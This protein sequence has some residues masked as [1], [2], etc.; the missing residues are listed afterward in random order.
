MSRPEAIRHHDEL[1]IAELLDYMAIEAGELG[2]SLGGRTAGGSIGQQ[3]KKGITTATVR[4]G[5]D[6]EGGIDTAQY[7]MKALGRNVSELRNPGIVTPM[8]LRMLTG[9]GVLCEMTDIRLGVVAV[10]RTT[11]RKEP[12]DPAVGWETSSDIASSVDNVRF[13]VALV[14][15]GCFSDGL[16]RPIAAT[17]IRDPALP[18]AAEKAYEEIAARLSLTGSDAVLY[19]DSVRWPAVDPLERDPADPLPGVLRPGDDMAFTGRLEDNELVGAAVVKDPEIVAAEGWA[20]LPDWMAIGKPERAVLAVEEGEVAE[21]WALP[22]ETDSG[23]I[24]RITD[25]TGLPLHVRTSI[26]AR[27]RQAI[28][29]IAKVVLGTIERN[30]AVDG[31]LKLIEARAVLK[32]GVPTHAA[33]LVR[34]DADMFEML[35][36]AAYDEP[37]KG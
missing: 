20:Q 10:A 18:Q 19:V 35:Y 5:R 8:A 28:A 11:T 2:V 15:V 24:L 4:R 27:D 25:G 1:E 13:A 16:V 32:L 30:K 3:L 12:W 36:S 33:L 34:L 21:V 31:V 29:R 22:G 9:R 17:L 23:V 37:V 26:S 7:A 6:P 14:A